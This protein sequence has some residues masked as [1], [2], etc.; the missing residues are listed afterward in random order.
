MAPILKILEFLPISIYI[1]SL[2]THLVCP[3]QSVNPLG[4]LGLGGSSMGSPILVSLILLKH[5]LKA[6]MLVAS[7]VHRSSWFVFIS[8]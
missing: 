1:T 3:H 2:V 7:T 5:P 4:G 6:L 8:I